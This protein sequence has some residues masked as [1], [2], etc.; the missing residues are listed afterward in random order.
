MDVGSAAAQSMVIWANCV[1]SESSSNTRQ[2]VADGSAPCR[3][4]PGLPSPKAAPY[5][6]RP[7]P[8][9]AS[10]IVKYCKLS[11]SLQERKKAGPLLRACLDKLTRAIYAGTVP[12]K[13][14]FQ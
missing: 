2:R 13:R 10:P 6:C 9:P 12:I 14:R 4:V 7:V 8:M 5:R 1:D 3:P 11:G